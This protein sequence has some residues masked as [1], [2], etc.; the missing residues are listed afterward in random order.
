MSITN[1]DRADTATKALLK[2]WQLGQT[3]WQQVDSE[4]VS[5]QKKADETY[6][7][8]QQLVDETRASIV[9]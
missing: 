6:A 4:Y 7:K 8:F 3:Y 2:A 9:N 1:E 5:H